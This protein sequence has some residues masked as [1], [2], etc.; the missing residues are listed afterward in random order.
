MKVLLKKILELWIPLQTPSRNWILLF[1]FLL[2]LLSNRTGLSTNVLSRVGLLL[3]ISEKQ[4]FE[5]SPWNE[6]TLDWS[7]TVDGKYYSNKAPGPS[8][9]AAPVFVFLYKPLKN[10]LGIQDYKASWNSVRWNNMMSFIMWLLSVFFQIVPFVWVVARLS[11]LLEERAI[12]KEAIMFFITASMFG[13]TGDFYMNSFHGHGYA[14]VCS[15]AVLLFCLKRQWTLTGLAL[16]LG[17]L[18]DYGSALL[19][20]LV[21]IWT[22][23][24]NDRPISKA[25]I[26]IFKGLS[27]P[28]AIFCAYHWICF[29]GPL[30]LPQ[31]FQNPIFVDHNSLFENYGVISW[32]P[33]FHII[34]QLLI[35]PVRGLLY[36]QPYCLILAPTLVFWFL[37]GVRTPQIDRERHSLGLISSIFFMGLLWMNAGFNGWHG[38]SA[39]GPRYLVAAFPCLAFAGALNWNDSGKL[40]KTCLW[41]SLAYSVLFFSLVLAVGQNPPQ[42]QSLISYYGNYLIEST[43][44]PSQLFLRWIVILTGMGLLTRQEFKLGTFKL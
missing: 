15:L 14:I 24:L 34:L 43:R 7:R 5:I 41:I 30:T 29:G 27:G 9:I 6:L 18:G 8:F 22:L 23:T 16:G 12:P 25:W 17:F 38:G 1:A 44:E 13:N 26:S 2:A 3:A 35:G 21:G 42:D 19:I 28:M 37:I 32:L 20:P 31:K 4:S 36:T 10:I 40:I 11:L 39:P 33:N